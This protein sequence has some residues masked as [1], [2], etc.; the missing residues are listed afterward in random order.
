M[1]DIK[2]PEVIK[3]YVCIAENTDMHL[4]RVLDITGDLDTA[5]KVCID[6]IYEVAEH[7][8]DPDLKIECSMWKDEIGGIAITYQLRGEKTESTVYKV[9]ILFFERDWKCI[10][11]KLRKLSEAKCQPIVTATQKDNHIKKLHDIYNEKFKSDIKEY[12]GLIGPPSHP[13]NEYMKYNFKY[14]STRVYNGEMTASLNQD[15]F[16]WGSPYAIIKENNAVTYGIAAH[17]TE[18]EDQVVFITTYNNP[19]QPAFGGTR[20]IGISAKDLCSRVKIKY[21]GMLKDE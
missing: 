3:Q 12:G 17:M 4:M 13:Q 5:K 16:R 20:F 7:E 2:E 1:N 15:A 19:K 9:K 6:H 8:Q 18:N 11:E 10:T 14:L 21:V